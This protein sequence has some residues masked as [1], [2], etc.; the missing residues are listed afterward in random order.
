MDLRC[1]VCI[2]KWECRIVV[3]LREMRSAHCLEALFINVLMSA[4][5]ER[6]HSSSIY[7]R[8]LILYAKR[9]SSLTACQKL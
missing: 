1:I 6:F 8:R 3:A 4:L 5:D 2:A 7:S 9:S